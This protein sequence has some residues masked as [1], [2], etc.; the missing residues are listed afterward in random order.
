MVREVHALCG[1]ISL[2]I[3]HAGSQALTGLSKM[4]AVGSSEREKNGRLLCRSASRDDIYITRGA[5][6]NY[7]LKELLD[8][9]TVQALQNSLVEITKLP[10]AIFDI[11]GNII[12][13]TSWEDICTNFHR[14]TPKSAT[15]CREN[16]TRIDDN[17]GE[18]L[19]PVVCHCPMGLID[20]ASPIVVE[21]QHLGNVFIG[22]I[23]M[24]Q[25]DETYFANQARQYGFHESKYLEAV[26]KV[27]ISSKENLLVNLNFIS[28]LVQILAENGLQTKRQHALAIE[29]RESEKKLKVILETS[30]AGIMVVSPIG[31]ITFANRR[32][33]EMF[34]LPLE[35]LIGSQYIDYVHETDKQ[36]GIKTMKQVAF[37]EKTSV[38]LTRHYLRK[39]GTDFWGNLIGT[40]FENIDG[41]MRDQVIVI[42]DTSERKR[43]DDENKLLEQ[44]LHQAQKLESLGVLASGIAHDFNNLLTVIMGNACLAKKNT[45]SA[46]GHLSSIEKA[47]ERAAGL[48]QQM[49][50]YA[51]K[52][53]FDLSTINLMQLVDEIVTLTRSTIPQNT[54]I[55]LS[56]KEKVL[57]ILGDSTQVSQI[58]MNLIINASEAIGIAQGEILVDMT[59]I[60]ITSDKLELDYLGNTILPNCY[61][62]LEVTDN[63][64]GMDE[65]TQ[66]R[67]FEPFY[68]TKFM[69]RGLGMSAVI[70]IVAKHNGAVQLKSQIGK[71]TTFRV[72]FPVQSTIP[73]EQEA[74]H[75]APFNTSSFL[76]CTILLVE[77]E[78]QVRCIAANMIR[79]MG[80]TIIEA[81]NGIEALE[82]FQE[83]NTEIKL[84]IT[85]I[86]MPFM[87]GYELIKRIKS[88]NPVLPIIALSGFSEQGIA[89]RTT[90]GDIAAFIGKPYKFDQFRDIINSVV[91]SLPSILAQKVF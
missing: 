27:P 34:C 53:P 24:G 38:E 19:S 67:I 59:T 54:A 52:A 13:A 83:H 9:P 80:F 70:G 20:A 49:M 39:D 41:S 85:D 12:T 58:I 57:Y 31:A 44:Q 3:A 48:C 30:E 65:E 25:P 72:L 40:R 55:K 15:K 2:Q 77:D 86:G 21:G 81:S 26:R 56:R 7:A 4:E 84:V 33:A 90:R 36:A 45:K 47:A 11:D 43:V 32:S 10:S 60:E 88:L 68:T 5:L 29:L 46:E 18:S 69:G 1:E 23:I 17:V 73:D 16:V 8:I 78:D 35:E 62:C 91:K 74:Q 87:D 14:V 63:G 51:G 79:K 75:H 82:V 64:D 71:G 61:A 66:K 76:N 28:I 22:Q 89:S 42:L 37:G 6:M 50:A